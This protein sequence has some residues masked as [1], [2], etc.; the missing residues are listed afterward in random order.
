MGRLDR[1]LRPK[2]L[3]VIGGGVWCANIIEEC[4][5]IGFGGEVFVVHPTK[6]EISGLRA[7]SS[8]MDLPIA[9][10]AVFVGVNRSASV[11]IAAQ[12]ADMGAG[13]AVFFASGFKE[14]RAELEDGDDLQAALVA[15]AGDMPFLG[16]NCY[17]FVNALDRVAVWPDQ[18]G[19]EPVDRGVAII[20]QSSNMAINLSMQSRGLLI[21][22]LATV[23]NQAVVD[24]PQLAQA[25][26]SDPRITAIGLHIEGISHLEGFQ[27]LAKQ[28]E[29]MGKPIVA[30]K[31]GAS[32]Q[33]QVATVSHTASL[34]GSHA[35]A[36]ALLRRLG[37][38]Q[39]RSLSSLLE[40]LKIAH[41]AG[42]LPSA[43]IASLSCSGGEASLMAD[44]GMAAG[45]VYPPLNRAQ[46]QDLATAL[47]PKV[48][49]ANPL[50][51]HTYIWG[52]EDKI[53]QT[54]TAMLQG[55]VALG[56]VVLDFPRPDRCDGAAWEIVISACARAQARSGR[57]I[58]ILASM[59]DT[60]HEAAARRILDQGLIPLV[61]M[62]LALEAIAAMGQRQAPHSRRL[63]PPRALA[64]QAV[65]DEYAAKSVLKDYG[66][67]VPEARRATRGDD[68]AA[69]AQVVRAPLVLKGMGAAHKSEAGLVRLGLR[70]ED[71]P[72]AANQMQVDA[73]LIEEMVSDAVAEVIVGI[74]CDPAHGYVLTLGAGGVMT[75][76]LQDTA[77][78]LLPTTQDEIETALLSLNMAPLFRGFRG[79]PA[80]DLGIV[81]SSILALVRAMGDHLD[82]WH[83]LEVNPLMCTPTRAVAVDALIETGESL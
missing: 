43:Q 58:A 57:P 10:D 77:Q 1:L 63:W 76:I 71:I 39:V 55:D 69:A 70:A 30:L 65:L 26:L 27:D 61:D 42:Y 38:A 6:V 74:T 82:Q 83:S 44:L 22:M 81:T 12:L 56:V 80:V 23:G 28:A 45:V 50:D 46:A 67:D 8:V 51:Y 60:M 35:G 24:I 31:V 53:A 49:L 37:F 25:L 48:A 47:G 2:S 68:L 16:P 79:A 40:A 36:Q 75:E 13:G 17:G 5:K 41:V 29:A 9:P 33:A 59:G 72:A 62:S 21:A 66:V 64:A 19:A 32:E 73:Y 7:V 34:A 15:A 20:T 18:H 4:R 14:A 3:A 54:F 78:L 11:T 52:D